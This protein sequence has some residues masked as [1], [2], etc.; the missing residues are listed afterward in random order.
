MEFTNSK[1]TLFYL[2][3]TQLGALGQLKSILSLLR[4]GSNSANGNSNCPTDILMY[5]QK[6][7][8]YSFKSWLKPQ[9][10]PCC[11]LLLRFR[12]THNL[13]LPFVVRNIRTCS[14]LHHEDWHALRS[15]LKRLEFSVTFLQHAWCVMVFNHI[16][17][18]P[19]HTHAHTNTDALSLLPTLLD[20]PCTFFPIGYY[21]CAFISLLFP[22]SSPIPFISS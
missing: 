1:I 9:T 13:F 4:C 8:C 6:Q 5:V 12:W 20:C 21:I 15:D 17:L 19:T 2:R 18:T 14:S 10:C 11:W 22:P 16:T 7:P 3:D